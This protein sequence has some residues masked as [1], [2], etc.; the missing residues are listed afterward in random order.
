M[1]THLMTNRSR[2]VLSPAS[3]RT[4]VRG[5]GVALGVGLEVNVAVGLGARAVL[6]ARWPSANSTLAVGALL[7]GSY[8]CQVIVLALV[9]RRHG[10]RFTDSIGLV[11]VAT[12]V[13]WFG[14]ALGGAVVVRSLTL[15]YSQFM[16][17][18]GYKLQGWNSDPTRYFA[19]GVLGTVLLVLIV[20]V[21]APIVE[22]SVFRGIMLPSLRAQWGDR[23]AVLGTAFVFAAMHLNL[24]SFLPIFA[25][26]V[27]LGRLFLDSKSLWVPIVCHAAFNGIGVFFLLAL[28]A[29][30][31]M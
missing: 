31:L 1:R 9:A 2:F 15:L 26:A 5:S 6:A 18:A 12:P 30:G 10:E 11:P 19:P 22:E 24:F 8:A 17:G 28:R 4:R 21:V 20:V 23:I 16:L 29:R 13:A 3:R 25:I 14:F 27:L 7:L